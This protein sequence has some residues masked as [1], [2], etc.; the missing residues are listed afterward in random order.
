MTDDLALDAR[1]GLPDA[2]RVLLQTYPRSEWDAH[3]NF[4]GLVQFW[5]ERHMMFRK[6]TALLREDAERQMDGALDPEQQQARL[7]RYGGALV[8]ELH[9]HHQIED[10]HYF[11]ALSKM[12]PGLV[13]GFGIL[14]KDHDAMD[15]LL[16]RFTR[17]ANGVLREGAEVGPFREE[18]L[19][20]DALLDRHL[21]DEE[22]LIVPVILKHG[23]DGIH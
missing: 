20:F 4:A 7:A 11:P 22:E 5:L 13:R 6:I 10:H 8:N 12:E 3:A 21:V 2:L 15:G 14:D 9:G 18:L 1:T 23:P 17:K 16:D 19:S